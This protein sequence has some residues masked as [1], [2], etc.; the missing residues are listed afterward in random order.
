MSEKGQIGNSDA[1]FPWENHS[2]LTENDG[3]HYLYSCVI[4]HC[5]VAGCTLK[6]GVIEGSLYACNIM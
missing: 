6:G 4:L 5:G 1:F 3:S 2:I